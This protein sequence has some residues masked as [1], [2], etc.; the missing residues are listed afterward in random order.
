MT[1]AHRPTFDPARGGTGRNEGDLSKLSAQY[2]A[3]DL[4]SH[5]KLKYREE[6]VDDV[7][8]KVGAF[9]STFSAVQDH[10][11][12]L[13][14]REHKGKEKRGGSSSASSAAPKRLRLE[15]GAEAGLDKDDPLDDVDEGDD[16]D[17]DSDDEEALMAE[18][19]AIKKERAAEKAAKD[20]KDA[21]EQVGL[22]CA[23]CDDNLS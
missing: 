8:V 6:F 23:A 15:S 16:S 12:A 10:R 5:K 21:A 19:A 14:E 9:P 1:T 20:A 2:S 7:R 4:P 22:E 11:H 17:D 3:K 18:L 13:E